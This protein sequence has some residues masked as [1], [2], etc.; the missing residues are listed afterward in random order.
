MSSNVE[1]RILEMQLDNDQFEK[2]IKQTIASLEELEEKL[3][4]KDSSDGF[5]KISTAAN[6]IQ[7]GNMERSLDSITDKFTLLGNIGLQALERISNKVVDIGENILKGLTIDPL[8]DGW[9]EFEMKTNSTQTILGGI[10]DNYDSEASALHAIGSELDRLNEYAD[11]TIYSFGQMT[12]NVGK[13]TNQ[14]IDLVTSVDA[15]KGIGNWAALVGADAS[16]MSRAMYNISQALGGGS[17]QLIDWKSIKYANMATPKVQKLLADIAK[18]QGTLRTSKGKAV[19]KG[20]KAEKEAYQSIINDFEKSLKT[21]WMTNDVMMQAFKILSNEMSEADWTKLFGDSEEAQ[22]MIAEYKRLGAEAQEAATSVK[23]LSQLIGVLKEGLGSGWATTFEKLFGGFA[24]QRKLLT[25]LS[26]II[27]ERIERDAK[28]RNTW[29]DRF[30]K[31]NGGL[32]YVQGL[33]INITQLFMDLWDIIHDVFGQ[34]AN[35]FEGKGYF[36]G[37]FGENNINEVGL[38]AQNIAGVV[39]DI[40]QVFA[41]LHYW[42]VESKLNGTTMTP[43][44]NLVRIFSGVG[45]IIGIALNFLTQFWRFAMKIGALFMPLAS[46]ILEM[47][48]GIGDALFSLYANLSGQHTFA[49]FFKNLY[50]VLQPV[51]T[52][53]VN[54]ASSVLR[55]IT[56]IL[57]LD[58]EGDGL[59]G[60]MHKLGP[61]VK[62]VSDAFAEFP[63]IITKVATKVTQFTDGVTKGFKKVN[64]HVRKEGVTPFEDLVAVVYEFT[65]A[66]F[67]KDTA[68]K[69]QKWIDEN[70]TG[71][72]KGMI[73]WMTNSWDTIETFFRELPDNFNKTIERLKAGFEALKTYEY[74]DSLSGIENFREMLN[75][76]LTSLFGK[77]TA[78][79]LMNGYD[80]YVAPVV[81]AI[82]K[83]IDAAFENVQKVLRGITKVFQGDYSDLENPF[84]VIEAIVLN[85]MSGY[86]E[87]NTSPEVIKRR[88]GVMDF[89]KIVSDGYNERVKP[90]I[91]KVT[92]WFTKDIPDAFDTISRFLFGYE[93]RDNTNSSETF[94]IEGL[95]DKVLN[96]IKGEGAAKWKE[97]DEFF[98]GVEGEAGEGQEKP[99]RVGGL[100][101]NVKGWWDS[102]GS[103]MWETIK[104]DYQSMRTWVTTTGTEV[105]N[106]VLDF[107]LG[108]EIPGK[109]GN[110]YRTGGFIQAIVNWYNENEGTIRQVFLTDIP[111]LFTAISEFFIGKDL[112]K[113]TTLA[114]KDIVDVETTHIPGLFEKIKNWAEGDGKKLV[115]EISK[116]AT[117]SWEDINRFFFGPEIVGKQG[118]VYR[119]GGAF[120]QVMAFLD[121]IYTWIVDKGTIIYDYLTTHSFSEMWASLDALLFGHK[122]IGK[123]GNSWRMDDGVLT[124]IINLL[125]PLAEFI[126][127]VGSKLVEMVSNIDFAAVWKKIK[128]F[129]LGY[130]VASEELLQLPGQKPAVFEGGGTKHIEGLFD[131]LT[132]LISRIVAFFESDTWK[133]IKKGIEGFYRDCVKP[134][135]D[136][137]GGLGGTIIKSIGG[138][139]EEG[140]F[141]NVVRIFTDGNNYVSTELPGLI[142]TLFKDFNL[143]SLLSFLPESIRNWF[144]GKS[145]PAEYVADQIE[146]N[147]PTTE[148]NKGSVIG[149]LIAWVFGVSTASAEEFEGVTDAATQNQNTVET[150]INNLDKKDNVLTTVLK[151][152]G[153]A[154]EGIL[155][156]IGG[157]I[158]NFIGSLSDN[159]GTVG[160]MAVAGYGLSKLSD[161]TMALSGNE[162][163]TLLKQLTGLF[164]A[165]GGFLNS[166]SLFIGV[167]GAVDLVDEAT[168]DKYNLD[169]VNHALQIIKDF[170]LD[171]LTELGVTSFL[172]S[173]A[174]GALMIAEDFLEDKANTTMSADFSSMSENMKAYSSALLDMMTAVDML[175][176][177]IWKIIGTEVFL[178]YVD[179]KLLNDGKKAEEG[180]TKLDMAIKMV[181]EIINTLTGAIQ[182]DLILKA[183]G[184]NLLGNT[185]PNGVAG[186][187]YRV[188]GFRT[189]NE[190]MA[191]QYQAIGSLIESI[192]SG[193]SYL[194]NSS[195]FASILADPDKYTKNIDLAVKIL[196]SVANI[197]DKAAKLAEWISSWK[198]GNAVSGIDFTGKNGFKLT[199]GGQENLGIKSSA[200]LAIPKLTAIAVIVLAVADLAAIIAERNVQ[201]CASIIYV[202]AS[203][204][205]SALKGFSDLETGTGD[206]ALESV[207]SMKDVFVELNAGFKPGSKPIDN[208][209]AFRTAL[210]NLA[211]G[212]QM[213]QGSLQGYD[214]SATDLIAA[215]QGINAAWQVLKSEDNEGGLDVSDFQGKLSILQLAGQNLSSMAGSFS[216]LTEEDIANLDVV[217]RYLEA[218][219]EVQAVMN[220]ATGIGDFGTGL[221][222]GYGFTPFMDFL[223][224]LS[225]VGEVERD[226]EGNIT[227]LEGLDPDVIK[228]A[229]TA[230]IEAI[231]DSA[232][233]MEK[234]KSFTE[235]G[236]GNL[237]LFTNGLYGLSEALEKYQEAMTKIGTDE[238]TQQVAA[239]TAIDMLGQAMNTDYDI[240]E[241]N[242][243]QNANTRLTLFAAGLKTLSGSLESLG[244]VSKTLDGD[245]S[246]LD[247]INNFFD[248]INKLGA[249]YE[250]FNKDDEKFYPTME[251]GNHLNTFVSDFNILQSAFTQFCQALV[252]AEGYAF[253]ASMLDTAAGFLERVAALWQTL[254]AAS[255]EITLESVYSDIWDQFITQSSKLVQ[256]ALALPTLGRGIHD[257]YDAIKNDDLADKNVTTKFNSAIDFLNRLVTDV[258]LKIRDRSTM[259]YRL[260]DMAYDLSNDYGTG[261][262]DRLGPVFQTASGF[263]AGGMKNAEEA[264]RVV[265]TIVGPAAELMSSVEGKLG[266]Y[267]LS[268]LGED[269]HNNSGTG[270]F[271][272]L[273]GAFINAKGLDAEGM[274]V[275]EHILGFIGSFS[276]QLANLLTAESSSVSFSGVDVMI[277]ELGNSINDKLYGNLQK[278]TL[279]DLNSYAVAF[280]D[281]L[282]AVTPGGQTASL[283]NAIDEALDSLKDKEITI[284][285]HPVWDWPT[286]EVP[287]TL[288][289]GATTAAAAGT[290][291]TYAQNMSMG[292]RFPDVQ[293]VSIVPESLAPITRSITSEGLLTRNSI[294]TVRTAL[295]SMDI[296]LDTGVLVG[297]LAP[298][299]N[300]YL[301]RN[302]VPPRYNPVYSPTPSELP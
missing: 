220:L 47:C 63:N 76:L 181:A 293:A 42:L 20:S 19:K 274:A 191:I 24:E 302:Y 121:P 169:S 202:A 301:G 197:L 78:D 72:L 258:D 95:F 188:T 271:D 22:K 158:G 137:F 112:E 138:W 261:L 108:P 46:T 153:E 164:D 171:L 127:G 235:A 6:S 245:D 141:A 120:D 93:G 252:P 102:T 105:V 58:K 55:L 196:E 284:T 180:K 298:K 65:E 143:E 88:L 182:W 299:I 224:E 80:Q 103:Q 291:N 87:G 23:T 39:N 200:I 17:M 101:Q 285:V 214:T 82:A 263:D 160:I 77:D 173:A 286:D 239:L 273:G 2:G 255:G 208:S 257:F 26:E 53:I 166:L 165:L 81:T 268:R 213:I 238:F 45:A 106:A 84:D 289:S 13:F 62:T 156:T 50:N 209:E 146:A 126:S 94:H 300:K 237:G 167:V 189:R 1:T 186:I 67:G 68:D 281:L 211:L 64:K 59:F 135:V 192:M 212:F 149:D 215:L 18:I 128:E 233:L 267:S 131:K 118:N 107:F 283:A 139:N 85:F 265:S 3:D 54:F 207:K 163:D 124:P 111:R 41:A 175:I 248:R 161:I 282:N 276:Q 74:N 170:I 7:F 145:D 33:V 184:G 83:A 92:K 198:W 5:Q 89:F 60:F 242:S 221:S 16:Q 159:L 185:I 240:L 246:Y 66:G 155:G 129:F 219:Q 260:N 27:G 206:K 75:I 97:I 61:V 36:Y 123:Q 40:N 56:V 201:R 37:I 275:A 98:F 279:T 32:E 193:V 254:G 52:S 90:F 15:M 256:L 177:D 140:F 8:V 210:A 99:G 297:Q 223:Y 187:I 292:I 148:Q 204:I 218:F 176:T 179:E 225:R 226:T 96:W 31:A 28:E 222:F 11:Q 172:T 203:Q 230:I 9:T 178:E 132:N 51:I 278:M 199:T 227:G 34:L 241:N 216:G 150:G 79:Q 232:D 244:N 86:D 251:F 280:T 69:V 57:G 10:K 4:L 250:V 70:I 113:T 49:R 174:D 295:N 152:G 43:Y 157:G 29:V 104:A 117:E 110:T 229:F 136:F 109:Q 162:K 266:A 272:Y 119:S 142:G 294:G 122:I 205:S 71:T 269:L 217:K 236:G 247:R 151:K 194:L 288:D 243:A 35:P 116:F 262:F 270:L 44:Q 133:D 290:A 48:G 30:T 249:I 144:L 147:V 234:L 253:D 21:G 130:D 183:V 115:E 38:T 91:G 195:I 25:A 12:E 264:L 168:K 287:T 125:T 114:N 14:N 73:E 154:I 134:I 228:G 100:V 296:R 190:G 231:P 277:E 259:S